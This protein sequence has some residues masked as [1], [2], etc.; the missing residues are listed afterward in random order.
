MKILR[1]YQEGVLT[2][3]FNYFEDCT[4]NPICCVA[5]GGGKSAIIAEFIRRVLDRWDDQRILCLSHSKEIISQ[6]IE[7]AQE[8]MPGRKIGVYS[9]ALKKRDSRDNII[10]AS[11]QSVHKKPH[12][13]GWVSL[14]KIDECHAIG[15]EGMYRDFIDGLKKTN[16][17]LKVIGYS[18]TPYRLKTGILTQGD[19]SIFT[20]ICCEITILQLVELGFLTPLVGRSS[21]T[22]ADLSQVRTTAGEYN[23]KDVEAAFD[24][25]KL[26]TAALDEVCSLAA[27]RN[28]WIFFCSGI[29][30]ATHVRDALRARGISA[31]AVSSKTPPEERE[32]ILADYQEGKFRAICNSDLLTVGYNCPRIDCVIMLRAT[33]SPGLFVQIAGRAMRLF[34]G[35]KD[36]LLLDYGL[37]LETHGCITSITPP[38]SRNTR[39]TE[40][41]ERTCLICPICRMASEL[42]AIDCADCGYVF[43][44][45]REIKH[46]TKASTLDVMAP[47]PPNPDWLTVRE[48]EYAIH[49]GKAGKPNTLRVT[50]RCGLSEAYSEW[51]CLDHP[52]G[53]FAR[54]NAEKWWKRRWSDPTFA[55]IG[56]PHG[57]GIADYLKKP[58]YIKVKQDGKFWKVTAYDFIQ[59]KTADAREPEPSPIDP[60]TFI[61]F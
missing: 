1:D 26:T 39:K 47:A 20:D 7:A 18:A 30:H 19:N 32:R 3:L 36:A 16:P 13:F 8:Q 34:P 49:Q 45:T 22:Q 40:I 4:G 14:L 43:E 9:A 31:E 33:K 37:N 5:T 38:R 24:V 12:I 56:V 25:D 52:A 57:Y 48:V 53:S 60:D 2:S 61:P 17:N 27:D 28:A 54:V 58:A 10:F 6:N 42:G 51:V 55:P 59:R 23:S 44:R 46:E 21:V 15:E 50:Y 41:N 11:I 35:K 29:D